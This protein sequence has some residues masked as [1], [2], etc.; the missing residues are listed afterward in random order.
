MRTALLAT[1][2]GARERKD[3]ALQKLESR[4]HTASNEFEPKVQTYDHWATFEQLQI[5]QVTNQ[6]EDYECSDLPNARKFADECELK[7]K[8]QVLPRAASK[9][10]PISVD[11]EDLNFGAVSESLNSRFSELDAAIKATKHNSE[12][13]DDITPKAQT[14]LESLRARISRLKAELRAAV[15]A[16][17]AANKVNE[18]LAVFSASWSQIEAVVD[19]MEYNWI[20]SV[21]ES[22]SSELR[23]E[24]VNLSS[25]FAQLFGDA[26]HM[27]ADSKSSGENLNRSFN[28]TESAV[29]NVNTAFSDVEG[30]IQ[31][32]EE[33]LDARMTAL[34][35]TIAKLSEDVASAMSASAERKERE[36]A[37][38]AEM[39][40]ALKVEAD[41][42]VATLSSDWN[43]FE[44]ANQKAQSLQESTLPA[45][46]APIDVTPDIVSRMTAAEKRVK[47]CCD[48]I[49]IW[50]KDSEA[51]ETL[52]VDTATLPVTIGDL[53]GELYKIEARIQQRDGGETLLPLKK[54]AGTKQKQPEAPEP[55]C[56]G[57]PAEPIPPPTAKFTYAEDESELEWPTAAPEAPAAHE[58]KK[59]KTG[60]V[61]MTTA[62]FGGAST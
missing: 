28:Q 2:R 35:E 53:E 3:C 54:T 52:G 7:F 21:V 16:A 59:R 23:N 17:N 50:K 33:E 5:T 44:D 58:P 31:A 10:K 29:V 43:E 30:T 15:Q 45:V 6:L 47:W 51:M 14:Y 38:V 60:K 57:L 12:S 22:D 1:I 13:I 56:E 36:N 24:I 27:L 61:T 39:G 48:R 55:K 19:D 11:A 26:I 62:N 37:D 40:I 18:E 8:L 25:D 41:T 4:I 42:A 9:L 49:Q 20:P 34:E 46:A 32:D